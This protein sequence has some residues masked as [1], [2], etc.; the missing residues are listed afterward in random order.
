MLKVGQAGI[1]PET[2]RTCDIAL[3]LTQVQGGEPVFS[4]EAVKGL[5]QAKRGPQVMQGFR[6]PVCQ[7]D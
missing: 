1:E 4:P 5:R 3:G 2:C 6:R 7:V